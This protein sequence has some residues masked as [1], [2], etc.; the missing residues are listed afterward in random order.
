[1]DVLIYAVKLA[2]AIGAQGPALM[3]SYLVLSGFVLTLLRKPIAQMTIK[4]QQNEGEFR[5]MNSRLITNSEEVAF[6]QGHK[7]E[8]VNIMN[9][10]NRLENQFRN[11]IIFRFSM[12]F[13]DNIVAKCKYIYALNSLKISFV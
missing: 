8:E 10:F 7:R 13:I 2:N 11:S 9:S 6:Y 1:M 12:G 3:L 4:E 5:Y